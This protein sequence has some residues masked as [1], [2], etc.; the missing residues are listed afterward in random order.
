MSNKKT[1][2]TLVETMVAL[3]L[4]T[5][6]MGPV[7]I[8]VTSAVNIASRIEHNLIA[9]NLAQEGIE[10]IRNIR[11]TNW[12]NETVFDNNLPVGIWRVEW[13]TIGGG[14]MAVGPNPVLK[15]NNGLY[16]YSTGADTVFRRTV[17]ISKP[18][19]GELMLIS[20]VA[21]T[22]RGNISRTVSAESHLF[23]WK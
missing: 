6:A 1:G 13:N 3:L 4:V 19:G 20:S 14:L 11:D 12:L 18:N 16:N 23:D 21:W 5:V 22:E 7:F 2:F 8:L 10:T 9:T 17:T 15:K